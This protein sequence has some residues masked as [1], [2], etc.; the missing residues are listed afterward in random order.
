MDFTCNTH[1]DKYNAWV[2]FNVTPVTIYILEYDKKNSVQQ[3]K[4]QIFRETV[5]QFIILYTNIEKEKYHM[6]D[7]KQIILNGRRMLRIFLHLTSKGL[8]SNC[9]FSGNL[10]ST[11]AWILTLAF[12]AC[13]ADSPPPR[14]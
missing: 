6:I 7:E 11:L 4:R 13:R 9:L 10:H 8:V 2:L 14:L 12:P 5:L 1:P 3:L